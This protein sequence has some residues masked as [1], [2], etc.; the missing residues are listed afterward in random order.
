MNE[1][2][3]K[4]IT[5]I[6]LLQEVSFHNGTIIT[7]LYAD[8]MEGLRAAGKAICLHMERLGMHHVLSEHY[9]SYDTIK[10]L[11]QVDSQKSLMAALNEYDMFVV[12]LS[13][14]ERTFIYLLMKDVFELSMS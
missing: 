13:A 5:I 2:K 7:T 10:R 6:W 4:N 3:M 8:R 1:S 9:S 14:E 11:V 12:Y